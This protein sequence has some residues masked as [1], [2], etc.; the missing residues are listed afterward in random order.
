MKVWIEV[1]KQAN[2]K[3]AQ[4][5]CAKLNQMLE[6]LGDGKPRHDEFFY[7]RRDGLCYGGDFGYVTL[8]D[9]G[10]WFNL[11]YLGR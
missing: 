6:R 11:D 3:E 2:E 1:P 10:H 9:N 7:T 5:T 4:E 8:P